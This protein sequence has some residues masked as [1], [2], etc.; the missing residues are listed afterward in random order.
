MHNTQ[1]CGVGGSIETANCCDYGFLAVPGW[2][3]VTGLGSPNFQ[4]IANLVSHSSLLLLFV[5]VF[6]FLYL[7]SFTLMTLPLLFFSSLLLLF[8]S[9]LS[10]I[11]FLPSSLPY[12]LFVYFPPILS[13]FLSTNLPTLLSLRPPFYPLLFP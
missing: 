11:S 5:L 12:F 6:L 8:S 1:A 7:L 13:F 4:I 10:L 9:S 2:D 3:A